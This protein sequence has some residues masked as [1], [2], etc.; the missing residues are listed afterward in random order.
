LS[1]WRELVCGAMIIVLPASLTAQDIDRAMLHSPG[2]VWL[3]G[4]PAPES[5]AIFPDDLIQTEA[6]HIA[7]IDAD[8][9][10]VTIQP[11]TIL[12]FEGNEIVLDHGRLQVDTSRGMKV[13]VNCL[14]VIPV[15]QE[16]TQ[17]DVTDVDG[18]VTVAALK[19]DVNIHSQSAAA[20]RMKRP[21]NS[22]D[23]SVHEGEQTTRDE[24]CPATARLPGSIDAKAAF[25]S[26][27]QAKVAGLAAIGFIC[28]ALCHTDDPVSP[29]RP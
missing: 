25:L 7:K 20:Q 24:H 12:Q 29:Y 28:L 15:L 27:W 9:S 26:T 14:T 18:K 3:N 5:S 1:A 10:T 13:R 16:W 17:Y 19:S 23:A 21:G 2:G 11:E 8:G 6:N 22:S 4:K